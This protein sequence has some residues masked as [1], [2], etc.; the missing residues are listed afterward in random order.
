MSATL[1]TLKELR[2]KFGPMGAPYHQALEW[3]HLHAADDDWWSGVQERWTK[4]LAAEGFEDPALVFNGFG[5]HDDGGSFSCKRIDLEKYFAAVG[6][7][8]EFPEYVKFLVCQR[9]GGVGDASVVSVYRIRRSGSA[10][11]E[12]SMHLDN[13]STRVHRPTGYLD[14]EGID[15]QT[16]E[17]E[18]YQHIPHAIITHARNRAREWYKDVEAFHEYLH[19]EEAML[20]SAAENNWTF[21]E[22]GVR[23]D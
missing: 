23:H 15:W 1:Y 22:D 10:Y 3:C 9:L 21:D 17:D 19:S 4:Q 12:Q 13:A 11:H 6:G 2:A 14:A 7:R 8:D 16:L 20:A 18:L 5:N